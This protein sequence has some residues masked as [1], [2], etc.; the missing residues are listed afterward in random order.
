MSGPVGYRTEDQD[1]RSAPSA[2][3]QAEPPVFLSTPF[4]PGGA[5]AIRAARPGQHLGAKAPP[6]RTCVIS[7]T[8]A[9][10]AADQHERDGPG[11]GNLMVITGTDRTDGTV[12]RPG[13]ALV[14]DPV[15]ILVT[16]R[17][18]AARE[19]VRRTRGTGHGGRSGT[20]PHRAD[21]SRLPRAAEVAEAR[22]VHRNQG[23]RV[24][25]PW[26]G[27]AEGDTAADVAVLRTLA[28]AAALKAA[29]ATAFGTLAP[30]TRARHLSAQVAGSPAE[31]RW[32]SANVLMA[33]SGS[34]SRKA[35]V[36]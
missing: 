4:R 16:G 8:L 23:V 7:G 36:K 19:T 24:I 9:R 28:D 6:V 10:R 35:E 15:P 3:A 34:S 30:A 13:Q 14:Q 1:H 33:G 18:T 27:T 31:R 22:Q 25:S 5:G 12:S 21:R 29:F 2:V 20:R 32:A 17:R 26:M 11:S